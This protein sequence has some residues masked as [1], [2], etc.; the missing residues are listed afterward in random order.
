[1]D[2]I[3]NIKAFIVGVL[4]TVTVT[5]TVPGVPL[6]PVTTPVAGNSA[7]TSAPLPLTGENYHYI[8]GTYS[9]LGA[10]IKYHLLIPKNGGS[11]SG[12]IEGACQAQVGGNSTGGEEAQINGSASGKCRIVFVNYQGSINF[13]GTL[14]PGEKKIIVKLENAH[15]HPITLNYN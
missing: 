14:I 8:K 3:N 12:S 10:N 11:F 4:A 15:L 9:Y 1:M 7:Q 13:K 2:F 5:A 6:V